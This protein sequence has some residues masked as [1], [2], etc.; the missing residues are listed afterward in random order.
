M[1]RIY[2]ACV[3]MAMLCCVPALRAD[4]VSAKYDSANA[5][6]RSGDYKNASALYEQV[7]ANSYESADLYF[8][9]GNA[10]FKQKNIP[11][12]IL[13]YERARRLAPHDDDVLYNLRLCNVR[14]IDRIDPLPTLFLLD[15][16]RAVINMFSADG[17]A[18]IA[19]AAMW[20]AIVCAAI[21]LV[22]RSFALRRITSVIAI[23]SVLAVLIAFVG[24][25]QRT[26]IEQDEQSA[27][28]MTQTA[29]VKSAPDA[30]STDLFVLHEGL[31]MDVLDSVGN[32]KKIRLADGKIG[33]M[34]DGN[35]EII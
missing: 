34:A 10:Y 3:M 30:Q 28:V 21:F 33:W 9:L 19:V 7:I 12:A 11:A 16:Y 18:S 27:I 4:S 17:W 31:K 32:W 35:L 13:N 26:H 15:W 24:V 1:R 22:A 20:L 6:Y 5:A 2:F 23:L 29:S 8:N 14:I 25:Y